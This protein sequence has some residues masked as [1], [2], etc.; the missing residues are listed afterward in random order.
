MEN[1][2]KLTQRLQDLIATGNDLI[3]TSYAA[4]P[5][6]IGDDRVDPTKFWEWHTGCLSFLMYTFG[7]KTPH[8]DLFKTGCTWPGKYDTQTGLGVIKAAIQDVKEGRLRKFTDI[9]T[10][11]LFDNF[12]EMAEYLLSAKYKDPAAVL[13]GGVLEEHLR[14][15][16]T[17]N[18]IDIDEDGKRKKADKMNADLYKASVYNRLDNKAVTALLDLR[19]KAAHGEYNTYTI[20]Q[21]SLMLKGVHDFLTRTI[22]P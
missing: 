10:A 2:D 11:E 12:L 19:N 8:Y 5:D 17:H 4:P 20:E 1:L 15:L 16:C 13:I 21:V 6:V 9:V 3:Q 22:S 14:N 18:T 7:N